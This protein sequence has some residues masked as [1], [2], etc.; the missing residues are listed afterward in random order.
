M[1]CWCGCSN[2]EDLSMDWTFLLSFGS[3]LC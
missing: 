2:R 3:K 1:T